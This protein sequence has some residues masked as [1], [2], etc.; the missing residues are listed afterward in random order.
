MFKNRM[1]C[2]KL[3]KDYQYE[4]GKNYDII[5]STRCDLRFEDKI[6]FH[7]FSKDGIHIPSNNDWGGINDQFAFGNYE[8]MM[9]YLDLYN[10]LNNLLDR[11]ITLHPETLLK[12]HL[13]DKNMKISRFPSDYGIYR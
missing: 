11:G 4:T 10:N 5:I 9:L 13:I 7:Q 8:D 6:H 3:I 1:N 2:I 12:F